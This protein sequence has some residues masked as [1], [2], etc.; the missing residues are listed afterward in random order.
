MTVNIKELIDRLEKE[1]SLSIDEYRIIIDL[2]DP[3]TAEYAAEKA[4]KTRKQIYGNSVF[5]R[6]LIEVSNVCRR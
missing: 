4:V 1:H 5:I 6:G 3:E 2:R